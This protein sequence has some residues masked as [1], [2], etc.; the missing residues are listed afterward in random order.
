MVTES[1]ED[2]NKKSMNPLYPLAVLRPRQWT[3]NFIAF[4]PL[5]FSHRFSDM[6]AFTAVSACTACLCLVSGSVYVA[7]DIKDREADAKH[8][9]KRLRPIASGRVSVGTAKIIGISALII[10][11]VGGFL[12]RPTVGLTLLLYLLLQV[13][14]NGWLKKQPILDV[15]SIATGFVLRA[16]A[17][18]A[19][20][21][22][23][24]SAWF[25]LCT[26]LGALFLAVEKR[27]QELKVLGQKAGQHRAVFDKYSLELISRM[28]AVVVPSL[29]TSYA[30][31][32]FNSP[33]SQWMMITVPFVMYGIFRY[34][35]L[36]TTRNVTGAP[37]DV[38]LKDR[39]IQIS[40]L[41]WILTSV[42]VI[43]GWIPYTVQLII[44]QVDSLKFF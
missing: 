31:Y 19:A 10:G 29:I 2:K 25:L 30:I 32:S 1:Q 12:V 26:T 20:G 5:L 43:Y 17:G 15:F 14:Y 9:A 42:G 7:N 33:S 36:S 22:V 23:A 35:L 11:L 3:K 18:G 40:I 6:E 28:E 39:P 38:L 8:P 4:A 24:L 16:V 41:L 21:H 27:R 37:E 13:A 44:D 34:Q